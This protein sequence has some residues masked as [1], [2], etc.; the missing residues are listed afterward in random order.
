[1]ACRLRIESASFLLVRIRNEPA[2]FALAVAFNEAFAVSNSS[3]NCLALIESIIATLLHHIFQ[4]LLI[5]LQLF[6]F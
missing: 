4:L 3:L 5:D 2:A 6:E 1:M